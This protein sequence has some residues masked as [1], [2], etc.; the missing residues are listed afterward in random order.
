MLSPVRR[1][2]ATTSVS[3][4]NSCPLHL[5]SAPAIKWHSN[6]DS[7]QRR[8][9]ADGR[10]NT[11]CMQDCTVYLATAPPAALYPHALL[12]CHVQAGPVGG[13]TF[14]RF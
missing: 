4:L 9:V 8:A 2:A 14:E 12:N 3:Q 5:H 10:L 13:A 6:T 1:E 11:V 7:C